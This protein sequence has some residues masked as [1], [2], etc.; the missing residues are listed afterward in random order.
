MTKHQSQTSK[1]AQS[2]LKKFMG[3]GKMKNWTPVA[4]NW[5]SESVEH[6]LNKFIC[7]SRFWAGPVFSL[8][9]C[10]SLGV[11]VSS[12]HTFHLHCHRF[13]VPFVSPS[14]AS[15]TPAFPGSRLCALRTRRLGGRREAAAVGRLSLL[16]LNRSQRQQRLSETKDGLRSISACWL[17]KTHRREPE[18]SRLSPFSTKCS[19]SF[20][21]V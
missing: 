8:G 21:T 19:A 18:P 1:I 11:G 15:W 7:S 2:L 16:E 10:S 9:M 5:N 6:H 12:L 4:Q 17:P 3:H 14:R 13:H 20:F